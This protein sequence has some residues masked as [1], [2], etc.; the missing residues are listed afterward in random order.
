MRADCGANEE[1]VM[2]P[3]VSAFPGFQTKRT[4]G[5]AGLQQPPVGTIFATPRRA[6]SSRYFFG[7]AGPA[8]SLK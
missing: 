6:F 3:I 7:S 1:A 8:G 4:G 2:L 5:V